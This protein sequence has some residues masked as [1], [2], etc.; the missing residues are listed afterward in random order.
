MTLIIGQGLAGTHLAYQ[1]MQA[2]KKILIIDDDAPHTPD[3][4]QASSSKTAAGIVLPLTGRRIVKTWMADTLIPYALNTYTQLE[5]LTNQKFYTRIPV[6]ELLT[7]PKHFNDWQQRAYDHSPQAIKNF[8]NNKFSNP[9]GIISQCGTMKI[10]NCYWLNTTVFLNAMKTYFINQGVY[11]NANISYDDLHITNTEI[12]YQNHTASNAIFCTGAQN[13]PPIFNNIPFQLSKGEILTI[14]CKELTQRYIINSGIFILPIGRQRFRVGSTYD[15][16]D[17]TTTPTL[18]AREKLEQQLKEF[19]SLP[20]TVIDHQAA[21]RPTIKERK[22]VIGFHPTHQNI[23]ILNGLG[24]KGVMLA[25]WFANH[26]TN[27]IT[28][29][30]DL[31][32]EVNL[33]RFF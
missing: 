27:H 4:R 6:L 11:L 5:N 24:T 13:I 19:L 29:Q 18:Y 14:Y 8:Y 33:Q 30:T 10:K 12:T 32:P 22:P 16:Q 20:Y 31:L 28:N 3:C 21:I 26:F 1:L 15:W 2:G 23:G 9:K 25:P 7:T 17:L